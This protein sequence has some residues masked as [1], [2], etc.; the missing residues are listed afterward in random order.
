MASIGCC[1]LVELSRGEADDPRPP[2]ELI[3]ARDLRCPLPVLKAE[4]R[5]AQLPPGAVLIVLAT[6]GAQRA[7]LGE[8]YDANSAYGVY[9]VLLLG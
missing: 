3:D 1:C 2:A 9:W 5:L 7:G 6:A 8:A 4:P